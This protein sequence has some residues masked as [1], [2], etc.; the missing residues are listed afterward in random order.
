MRLLK[1]AEPLAVFGKF[2]PED[3][4]LNRWQKIRRFVY[5]LATMSVKHPNWATLWHNQFLVVFLVFFSSRCLSGAYID[6]RRSIIAVLS[7]C[8]P[9]VCAMGTSFDRLMITRGPR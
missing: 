1:H 2:V 4:K 7:A 3:P 6:L 9:C 5:I 8:G